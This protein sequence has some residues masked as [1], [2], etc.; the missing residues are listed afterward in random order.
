MKTWLLRGGC[1]FLLLIQS[2]NGGKWETWDNCRLVQSES[3][4]GDSFHVRKENGTH[5]YILRLYFVDAAETDK[6]F[7]E[8]IQDQAD[9]WG[10]DKSHIYDLGILGRDFTESFMKNGFTVHTQKEDALGRSKKNRYYALIEKD[11]EFLSNA[12][13]KEGL[14]RIYGAQADL[15]TGLPATP[16]YRLR[17]KSS[18]KQAKEHLRGAWAIGRENFTLSS[19]L[20]TPSTAPDPVVPREYTGQIR[21]VTHVQIYSCQRPQSPVGILTPGM[22]VNVVNDSLQSMVR[23]RFSATPNQTYEAMMKLEDLQK[24]AKF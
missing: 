9:Y 13:V 18:E 10:I 11:N 17:L 23:I 15:P 21:I 14:A 3:N 19:S 5:T 16:R 20:S 4:D 7:Q 6:R 24:Q 8:R 12:L 22:K 1:T 2:A